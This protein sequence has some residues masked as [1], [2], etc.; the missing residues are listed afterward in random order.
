M[1]ALLQEPGFIDNQH[2]IG[3]AERFDGVSPNR[4]SQTVRLPPAPPEQRLHPVRPR[5][6][7]LLGQQPARL[8][9]DPG[10]QSVEK[11]ATGLPRLTPAKH[12]T[13]PP[14]QCRKLSLPGHLRKLYADGVS[15]R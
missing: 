10:Q 14:L 6:P 1:R 4:I 7:R 12:R 8:A 13:Q 15:I 9:R 3:I 11:S 2:A 5:R